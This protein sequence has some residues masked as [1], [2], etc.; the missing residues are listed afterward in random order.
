MIQ[1]Q[2]TYYVE[3]MIQLRQEEWNRNSRLGMYLK[4]ALERKPNASP[5]SGKLRGFWNKWL[6]RERLRTS[7]K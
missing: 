5:L 4:Q 2:S 1:I 3:K 7:S 6:N